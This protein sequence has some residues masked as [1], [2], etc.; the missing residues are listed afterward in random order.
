MTSNAKKTKNNEPKVDIKALL[1]KGYMA[2]LL[3][4]SKHPDSVYQFVKLHKLKES[5]FYEHFGSFKA[6]E[7]SI[8]SQFFHHTHTLL[9]KNKEYADFDAQ[10]KLTSFYYTFFDMLK[11]N[12]SYV[13]MVLKPCQGTLVDSPTLKHLKKDFSSYIDSLNIDM[14]SMKQEK[15][16]EFQKKGSKT[17]FWQ[18]MLFILN[19][20]LS[21]SSA[22]FEKT[23]ILIEK[24]MTTSFQLMDIKPLKSLFDLGKFILKERFQ[25]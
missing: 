11:A 6:L 17:F 1:I 7:Q 19:F 22:N 23:D 4:H 2:Y 25:N 18:Q 16:E 9:N 12:R 5:D 15:L 14:M 3:E 20:W 21:D 10:N 8:F 24:A 13:L